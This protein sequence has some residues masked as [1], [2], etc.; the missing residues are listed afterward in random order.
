MLLIIAL[1]QTAVPL[2]PLPRRW[3]QFSRAGALNH[4]TETVEIATG[5]RDASNDFP[6]RLR[7]I[8]QSTEGNEVW[9]ADSENCP[10][11][12]DVV[13]SMKGIKMPTFAPYGI[14]GQ[15][16]KSMFD[17][18]GYSLSAPTSDIAG[19]VTVSSNNR[20]SIAIWIDASFIQLTPCW[21]KSSF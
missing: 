6:Y 13:K 21:R 19:E 1:L 9:M 7:L 20:S 10:V 18:T 14:P 12:L 15:S 5:D 16:T 11:I 8:K 17:G 3:A 4:I 2:P